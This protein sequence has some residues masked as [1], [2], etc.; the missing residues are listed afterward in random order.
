MEIK[1]LTTDKVKVNYSNIDRD[2]NITL[3]EMAKLFQNLFLK[4]DEVYNIEKNP[5]YSWIILNYDMNITRYPKYEEEIIL[6][7]YPVSFNKFYGNRIFLAEDKNGE[8]LIEAKTK[9]VLI[10][11]EKKMIKTLDSDIIKNYGFEEIV[12]GSGYGV[13]KI[14]EDIFSNGEEYPLITRYTD[15]DLN[16]HINNTIYFSYIYDFVDR[17]ILKKYQVKNI[18]INYKKG[19]VEDVDCKVKVARQRDESNNLYSYFKI[20]SEDAVHTYIKVLWEEK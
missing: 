4:Q 15:I 7:T 17:D 8:V 3:S 18:Q 1:L 20:H 10:D 16:Q 2:E 5:K 14:E 6:K 12:R 9:W 19:V 11:N 13:D